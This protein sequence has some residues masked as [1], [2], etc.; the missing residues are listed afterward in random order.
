[1]TGFISSGAALHD[2]SYAGTFRNSMAISIM[3]VTG[4]EK[5]FLTQALGL[6]LHPVHTIISAVG[7]GSAWLIHSS[8]SEIKMTPLLLSVNYSTF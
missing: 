1:M 4:S 5:P 7:F 3:P 8:S 6:P 2:C